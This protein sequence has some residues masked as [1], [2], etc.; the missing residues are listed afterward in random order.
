MYVSYKEEI[1]KNSI[2]I[3]SFFKIETITLLDIRQIS[4]QI[5]INSLYIIMRYVLCQKFRDC[6]KKL[7]I[8]DDTLKKLGTTTDFHKL[9]TKTIWLILIWITIIILLTYLEILW[10]QNQFDYDIITAIYI[11]S[12][13]NYC[14]HLNFISNLIF[15]S[16]LGLVYLTYVCIKK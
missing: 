1:Y 4:F 11:I 13:I 3:T 6:L 5:N 9:Y 8:V 14:S 7:I 2:Y 10:L 15:V 16:I 12:M